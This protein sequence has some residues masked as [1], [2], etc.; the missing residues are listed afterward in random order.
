MASAS[1]PSPEPPSEP[2]LKLRPSGPVVLAKT[3]VR[4]IRIK[5]LIFASVDTAFRHI[6][7]LNSEQRYQALLKITRQLQI[8]AT[9]INE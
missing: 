9:A 1:S 8:K 6:D 7:L 2:P 5:T 4:K 3:Y